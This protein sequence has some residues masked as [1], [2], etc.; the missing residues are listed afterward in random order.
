M[1]F[2]KLI[3]EEVKIKY[4]A[5]V[6]EEDKEALAF[7]LLGELNDY[8]GRN[9]RTNICIAMNDTLLKENKIDQIYS[10]LLRGEEIE[11]TT[12]VSRNKKDVIKKLELE[13]NDL[14]TLLKE[15]NIITE[16]NQFEQIAFGA[17]MKK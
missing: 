6:M 10:F 14:V 16:A 13:R 4:K 5:E 3:K 1:C 2:S 11:L 8:Y 7:T 15:A 9:F 17:F 12:Y